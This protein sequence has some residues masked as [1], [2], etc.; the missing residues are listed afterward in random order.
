MIPRSTRPSRI[1]VKD[2]QEYE[3]SPVEGA[4]WSKRSGRCG[5]NQAV[6]VLMDEPGHAG[7]DDYD[8]E[9]GFR[10]RHV[11][12]QALRARNR[13]G[14][15]RGHCAR[16]R[17]FWTRM[18]RVAT[19]GGSAGFRTSRRSRRTAGG[20]ISFRHR[21]N[22]RVTT[23]RPLHNCRAYARP[24][25]KRTP[26]RAP[27]PRGAATAPRARAGCSTRAPPAGSPA[28][29]RPAMALC[30]AGRGV[31]QACRRCT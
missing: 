10:H 19:R 27:P 25:F 7:D 13:R 9:V 4:P 21:L 17:R 6:E 1:R 14:H 18:M 12:V 2:Q 20:G 8:D 30:D 28:A 22:M 29:R 24:L 31:G 16:R 11:R 5:G 26:V 23:A 15:G 3:P